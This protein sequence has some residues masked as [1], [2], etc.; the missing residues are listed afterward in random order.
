[1]DRRS[2]R[3]AKPHLK[4]HADFQIEMRVLNSSYSSHTVTPSYTGSE[5]KG[6]P[7]KKNIESLSLHVISLFP[8]MVIMDIC[9]LQIK[10]FGFLTSLIVGFNCYPKVV[11]LISRVVGDRFQT[12]KMIYSS[13][14]HEYTKLEGFPTSR[15]LKLNHA[16]NTIESPWCCQQGFLFDF[17]PLLVRNASSIGYLA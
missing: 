11:I 6:N 2:Y 3:D 8:I 12:S 16:G 10:F 1:M 14:L 15:G 5:S 13:L 9:L 4:L 17:T 7:S